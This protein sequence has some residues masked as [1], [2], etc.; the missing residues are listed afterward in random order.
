[1]AYTIYPTINETFIYPLSELGLE[2]TYN[3]SANGWE[4]IPSIQ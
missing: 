4:V 2:N 3:C 1:M